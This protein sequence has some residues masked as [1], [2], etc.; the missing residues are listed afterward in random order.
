MYFKRKKKHEWSNF[1]L[2]ISRFL[3]FCATLACTACHNGS[4]I[5]WYFLWRL[6][7]VSKL[8]GRNLTTLSDDYKQA[9]NRLKQRHT[10]KPT[11]LLRL[12]WITKIHRA[13]VYTLGFQTTVPLDAV[14]VSSLPYLFSIDIVQ[15]IMLSNKCVHLY[16]FVQYFSFLSRCLRVCSLSRTFLVVITMLGYLDRHKNNTSQKEN[17]CNTKKVCCLDICEGILLLLFGWK[18]MMKVCYF[19]LYSLCSHSRG[20]FYILPMTVCKHMLC[21]FVYLFFFFLIRTRKVDYRHRIFSLSL[22]AFK[23][24]FHFHFTRFKC[25]A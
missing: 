12:I 24:L 9:T 5:L 22:T 19:G 11:C 3:L 6:K 16:H 15:H 17:D 20:N 1:M 4:I 14:V 2:T 7:Y 25:D 13:N 23:S 10:F 8:T 18:L 21:L